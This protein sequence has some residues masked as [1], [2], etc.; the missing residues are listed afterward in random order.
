MSMG[1]AYQQLMI[2]EIKLI[3]YLYQIGISLSTTYDY[4]SDVVVISALCSFLF[5]Q[6]L[7]D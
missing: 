1:L 5:V 4:F 7:S 6:P 3:Y 2:L